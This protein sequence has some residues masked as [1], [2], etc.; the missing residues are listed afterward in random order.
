MSQYYPAPS[1]FFPAL[2]QIRDLSN[3]QVTFDFSVLAADQTANI[4][5]VSEDSVYAPSREVASNFIQTTAGENEKLIFYRGLGNFST[6]IAV[7]SELDGIKIHNNSDLPSPG[8][9]LFYT[10]AHFGGV[11]DIAALGPHEVRQVGSVQLDQLR[12]QF[13][14]LGR[15]SRMLIQKLEANG[16]FHDEAVAMTETWK[17]S[18]FKR[19]GLRFLHILPRT[20]TD[21]LLPL[22]MAPT[23]TEL[24]RVLVGRVEI[25]TRQNEQELISDLATLGDAYPLENLGRLAEAKLRRVQQLVPVGFQTDIQKLIEKAQNQN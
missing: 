4:P 1:T 24:N 13:D 21:G 15:A 19:P 23:P 11:L 20:E 6:S 5:S 16:L 17:T 25:F 3:G 14:F 2:N 7:T 10:D 9:V 8:G 22:Q 18:Y 12:G